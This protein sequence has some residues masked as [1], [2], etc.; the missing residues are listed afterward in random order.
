M[1][2]QTYIL[3]FDTALNACSVALYNIQ[4]Q[5]TKVS[6]TIEMSRGQAEALIPMIDRLMNDANVTYQDLCAVACCRGPG[7]F[8]GLRL[9]IATA[10][11]FALSLNIPVYGITALETAAH[12]LIHKEQIALPILVCLETKRADYYIQAFTNKLEAINQPVS[13]SAKDIEV[14]LSSHPQWHLTGNAVEKLKNE[15]INF[16]NIANITEISA[17]DPSILCNITHI[18]YNKNNHSKNISP[19]YLRMADVSKP[20]NK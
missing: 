7:A 13:A 2:A 8:T 4:T 11:A 16:S 14:I 5:S 17:L 1:T 6:E 9:S 15:N 20:K 10:K 3:A 12:M 18:L 19:L